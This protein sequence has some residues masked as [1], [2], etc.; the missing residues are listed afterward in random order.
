MNKVQ[1]AAVQLLGW[2]FVASACTDSTLPPGP[3]AFERPN[4]VALVC[5]DRAQQLGDPKSLV[6]LDKCKTKGPLPVEV[7]PAGTTY[8]L[9][10]LVTQSS[11]GEV[12]AVDLPALQ[13]LDSRADIPGP[14]FVPTGELPV[15]ISVAPTHPQRTYV[16]N[17]GT[18]DISVMRTNAFFLQGALGEVATSTLRHLPLTASGVATGVTPFDMIMSPDEDALFVSSV[19]AGV[20][21]RI[22][23]QRCG[24]DCA[25]DGLP[26]ESNIQVIPLAGSWSMVPSTAEHQRSKPI[27]RAAISCRCYLRRRRPSSCPMPAMTSAHRSQRVSPSMCTATRSKIPVGARASC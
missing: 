13:V 27:A 14:T 15:A 26:D 2:C 16:A 22:G 24:D 25:E 11:R 19:E 9:H 10:A 7:P 20:L 3:A 1:S 17:A 8:T 12:A 6:A 21:L 18:R 5:V 4:R 23:I